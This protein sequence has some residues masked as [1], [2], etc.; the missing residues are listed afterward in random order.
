[1]LKN[2][3]YYILQTRKV[4]I[5]ALLIILLNECKKLTNEVN[6]MELKT[7]GKK[8][9]IKRIFSTKKGYYNLSVSNSRQLQLSEVTLR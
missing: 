6:K 1:M 3:N 5:V 4:Y 7:Y 9:L 8:S 2:F